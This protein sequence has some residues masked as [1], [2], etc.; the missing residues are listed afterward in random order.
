MYALQSPEDDEEAW[1]HSRFQGMWSAT[2]CQLVMGMGSG[3]RTLRPLSGIAFCGSRPMRLD[4]PHV[5]SPQSE[6][7][8]Q[9]LAS[10]AA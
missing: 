5:A 6:V 8:A 7:R 4:M 10:K 2:T 1:G 9:A 3:D